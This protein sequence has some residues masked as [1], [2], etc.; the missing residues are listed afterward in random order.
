MSDLLNKNTDISP[1]RI[2]ILDDEPEPYRRMLAET[3]QEEGYFVRE[4]SDVE[5]AQ[6]AVQ[7]ET[8]DIAL[9][10]FL[11]GGE[12]RGT[13]FLKIPEARNIPAVMISAYANRSEVAEAIRQ[14]AF[15]FLDKGESTERLLSVIRTAVRYSRA[16][17]R[18]SD[19]FPMIGSSPA[20]V[21][22]RE[23]IRR[24]AGS[25]ASVL[26]HGE[27]GTGKEAV[28]NLL[29]QFS[30]RCKKPFVPVNCSGISD[31]LSQ[32]ELFGHI[33]GAYSGAVSDRKGAFEAADGGTLYLAEIGGLSP[34]VQAKL[35]HPLSLHEIKRLG[36]DE[37]RSVDVRVIAA[38]NEKPE[39]VHRPDFL[40]RF[41]AVIE[42][43][44][45]RD[46]RQDIP[47][48]VDYWMQRI[49][50]EEQRY[51]EISPEAITYLMRVELPDNVRDIIR[52]LR[53]LIVIGEYGTVIEK[54]EVDAFIKD[55][56]TSPG[57]PFD[58]Q[59]TYRQAR[60]HFDF[61][62]ISKRLQMFGGNTQETAKSLRISRATLFE[63][64]RAC[65]LL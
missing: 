27:P 62:L 54:R 44:P 59:L 9:V 40:G 17:H 39:E 64:R 43:P 13:D 5:E 61:M 49:C 11:L 4:A 45:L 37:W 8:F 28:A 7:S 22:L 36:E 35:L 57:D 42:V 15:D 2:L 56:P 21:Q 30:P 51:R 60:I 33:K 24:W 65:G 18:P 14:G 26:I 10:D 52:I 19:R 32:S 3:L 16:L 12:S 58:P 1:G 63:K 38:T 23:S 31:E 20:M 25:R 48:I 46:R 41:D 47:E 29:H 6:S 50:A 53:N 34:A 55:E